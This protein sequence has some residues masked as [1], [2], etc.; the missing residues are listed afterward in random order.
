[1]NKG[2]LLLGS[3]DKSIYAA[4][5]LGIQTNLRNIEKSLG[6]NLNLNETDF[7]REEIWQR[8]N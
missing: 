6:C 4:G 8:K 7:L 2:I 5:V 1:L 3:N